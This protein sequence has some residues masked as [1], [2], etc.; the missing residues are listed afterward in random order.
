ML[1]FIKVATV[2]DIPPGERLL[3]EIDGIWILIFNVSGEFHAIEDMC[4]HEEYYL[5]EGVLTD[6]AIECTKHGAQ[7]DIR[8]GKPLCPP[9][10][11]PIKLFPIR[12]EGESVLV[13]RKL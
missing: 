4:S 5:S 7:F 2:N 11:S 10:V 8:T 12:V 13:G 6:H 9:A 1:Q 3:V